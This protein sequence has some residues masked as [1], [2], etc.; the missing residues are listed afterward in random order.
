MKTDPSAPWQGSVFLLYRIKKHS[1]KKGRCNYD[2]GYFAALE[3][4]GDDFF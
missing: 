3:A 4:E 1:M 2:G